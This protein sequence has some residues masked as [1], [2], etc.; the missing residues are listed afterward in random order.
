MKESSF[1]YSTLTTEESKRFQ[2][3]AYNYGQFQTL[4]GIDRDAKVQPWEYGSVPVPDGQTTARGFLDS[5]STPMLHHLVIFMDFVLQCTGFLYQE[6]VTWELPGSYG[7][8][9]SKHSNRY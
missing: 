3:T 8:S 7:L 1:A 6:A 9:E 2:I 4:F 5:F